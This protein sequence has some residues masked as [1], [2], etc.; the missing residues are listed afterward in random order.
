M[1]CRGKTDGPEGCPSPG[2]RD[3]GDRR[4]GLLRS[5]DGKEAVINEDDV[6]MIPFGV[7]G[8]DDTVM[9]TSF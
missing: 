2:R 3:A 9:R 7:H 8:S 5:R 6:L 4:G 1:P